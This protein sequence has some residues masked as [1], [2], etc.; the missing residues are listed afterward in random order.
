M[1]SPGSGEINSDDYHDY[2][3]KD[4]EFVGAFERMYQN[5]EDPWY[6][7]EMVPLAE[8]IGVRMLERD[9]ETQETILDLGCGKGR[10]SERLANRFG[11]KIVGMDV[12]K[13]AAT[14]A[15]SRS[16]NVSAIAAS[17]PPIPLANG[18]VPLIVASELLWY[19]L[20]DIEVLLDEISRVLRA[21]GH[22]LV[23]QQFYD[24]DE[25]TY[26]NEV[27]EEPEDFLEIQPFNLVTRV[28]VNPNTNWKLVA[29]FQADD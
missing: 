14:I 23:I 19:V 18:S 9:T 16:P 29:L 21:G 10:F 27:M 26:G 15:H 2:V 13:T 8:D 22:L 3:I 5:C 6:Q 24:R 25:Q 17:V 1:D 4:G 12:S 28:D 20:E 7:E 11:T